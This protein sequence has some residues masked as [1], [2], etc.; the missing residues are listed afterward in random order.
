MPYHEVYDACHPW[1]NVLYVTFM[2]QNTI[3]N[4]IFFFVSFRDQGMEEVQFIYNL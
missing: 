1:F 2:L 4:T 3:R